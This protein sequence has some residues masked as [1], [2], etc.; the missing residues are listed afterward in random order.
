MNENASDIL[1]EVDTEKIL[2]QVPDWF[3]RALANAGRSYYVTSNGARLHYLGWNLEAI[4]KPCLLFVHGYRGNAHWWDFIASHF[5]DNYR[6]IVPDLCGMGDSDYRNF[7]S[8]DTFGDD[9]VAVTS[10]ADVSSVAIIA[11]SFGGTIALATA[12]KYPHLID[13]AI[14]IDSY[15]NFT[16]SDR[17]RVYRQYNRGKIYPDYASVRSRYRLLPTQPEPPAYLLEHVAANAIKSVKNGWTWKNDPY[18]P[19]GLTIDDGAVLLRSVSCRVDYIYGESSV[20]IDQARAKRIVATLACGRGP[21][22]IPDAHHH[23]MLDQ[24]IALLCTL[25][26]LLL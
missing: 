8:V 4:D 11:H 15:F 26:A 17:E 21:I 19:S 7:Y 6:V 10:H 1:A 2:E 23:V 13:R 22:V 25:R 5:S 9:I 12:R 16:D 14:I 24:P 18:L 20:M 3:R